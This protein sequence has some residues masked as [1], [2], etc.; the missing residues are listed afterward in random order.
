MLSWAKR[1]PWSS[2]FLVLKRVLWSQ[3]LEHIPISKE[4]SLSGA[5]CCVLFDLYFLVPGMELGTLLLGGRRRH[6]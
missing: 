1:A 2:K 6:P 5:G 3:R 4:V